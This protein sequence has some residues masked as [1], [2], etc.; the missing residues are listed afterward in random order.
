MQ[1][2]L[3]LDY[4]LGC[5]LCGLHNLKSAECINRSL[6]DLWFEIVY[7]ILPDCS[8]DCF[9]LSKQSPEYT[10]SSIKIVSH[11]SRL[12]S[13]SIIGL[14]QSHIL[15]AFT[16]MFQFCLLLDKSFNFLYTI[17]FC[18]QN[19]WKIVVNWW[20]TYEVFIQNKW[21]YWIIKTKLDD[22]REKKFGVVSSLVELCATWSSWAW[23]F[24]KYFSFNRTERTNLMIKMRRS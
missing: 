13:E 8:I 3:Q 6:V 11:F 22:S 20:G 18:L 9:S 5:F 1:K 16:S 4:S 17:V 7:A 19:K 24:R 14:T 12:I 15:I 23:L 21:A 10:C 2:I